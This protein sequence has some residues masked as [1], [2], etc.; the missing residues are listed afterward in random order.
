L[1][2]IVVVDNP[3]LICGPR[4]K[5]PPRMCACILYFQKLESSVYIFVADNMGLSS[6]KFVQWAPK[7]ASFL[8]QSA[9]WPLK[10]VQGHPRSIFWYQSKARRRLPISPSLWLWSYLAQF[11]RYGD[12][13]AKN[14]LFL[15]PLSHSAPSLPMF[16][17]EFRGEVNPQETSH[18]AV[19]QWRPHDPSCCRFGMIP[20][21]DGRSDGQTESIMANTALCID[22][23]MLTCCKN[24]QHHT[25]VHNNH[26]RLLLHNTVDVG[27]YG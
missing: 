26:K 27:L 21:C 20:P 2:K 4:Q 8:Q 22:V 13:L 10:V 17:L 5:E 11:L 6:F 7:D 18:G 19:L 23:Y 25:L 24:H 9:F 1:P 3:T 12:L 16:P 15:I 14:C